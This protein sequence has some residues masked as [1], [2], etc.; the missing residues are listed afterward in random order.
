M[1]SQFEFYRRVTETNQIRGR[2]YWGINHTY[3][4]EQ[5][6]SFG[7]PQLYQYN[8]NEG[9]YGQTR[10]KALRMGV[11]FCDWLIWLQ[12]TA[13]SLLLWLCRRK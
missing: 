6:D 11:E 1:K 3:W 9:I 12:D 13:V 10:P 7:L 4:S 8:C 2:A 5:I